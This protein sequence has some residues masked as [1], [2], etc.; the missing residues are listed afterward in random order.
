MKETKFSKLLNEFLIQIKKDFGITTKDLT[1]EL[2]FSKNTFTNW[3]TGNSKP[4]FELLDKFYKFL[5]NF[6]KIYNINLSL[7]RDSLTAFKQLRVE[8]DR[9]LVMYIQEDSMKRDIRLQKSLNADRKETFH[10]N[11]SDF[12]E[13]LTTVSKSYKQ[14]YATE[15]SDY[16]TLNGNQKREFLD[17]LQSLKL[18]GFDVDTDE[19]NAIQK[20]LAKLIGVSEAQISRWKNGKDYPS[21]ANLKRIGELFNSYSD[22]PFSSYSFDNNRFQ[23]IFID[24]PKYS[25][26][27]HEFERTYFN[28]IKTLINSWGDR[29]RLKSKIIDE[30]YVM[31]YEDEDFEEIKNIFFRDSLMLFYKS[32]T[33]LNNDEE[34][35]DWIHKQISNEDLESYRCGSTVNFELKKKEDFESIAEE[36]DDG[37][38]QLDNFI[39]YGAHFDNV[40]DS[41]LK[42]ND[43]LLFVKTQIEARKNNDVKKIFEN[44]K[45]K[46]DAEGFI[47]DQ[48]RNLCNHL[49]MR[50]EDNSFDYVEAFYKQFWELITIKLRKPDTEIFPLDK[51]YEE[52]H[53]NSDEKIW[54]TLKENYEFLK[55]ELHDIYSKVKAI[56][57][58]EDEM[59]IFE[60]IEYLENGESLFEDVLLNDSNYMYEKNYYENSDDY[61][62]MKEI[63]RMYKAVILFEKSQNNFLTRLINERQI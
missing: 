45:E 39:N 23:S 63:E 6:E 30:S 52:P 13:F 29:D 48:S 14:E 17:T 53:L 24:T 40:R 57:I 58:K 8:I 62:Q 42:N 35:Q 34:F 41:V 59:L 55:N 21:Q 12:I 10:K 31:R 16:L 46:F 18:I 20:S 37:F 11:F 27:L 54:N 15:E 38:K 9:Q 43:L 3:K 4:T 60:L 7:N 49:T 47:R 26:V 2:D 44:A 28:Y 25:N 33:Y 32:F 50:N 19:K 22:T 56:Y 61:D 36:I 51:I 1:K 5:Q